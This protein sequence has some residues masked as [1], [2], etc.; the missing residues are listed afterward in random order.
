MESD[1]SEIAVAFAEYPNLM[2]N[3]IRLIAVSNLKNVL[4]RNSKN[5]GKLLSII[6]SISKITQSS[7][8]CINFIKAKMGEG[9]FPRNYQQCLKD[10]DLVIE[11][12]EQNQM[13]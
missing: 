9:A 11:E 2:T 13:L 10:I 5:R 1:F 8:S 3:C 12:L 4:L 7:H 6:E